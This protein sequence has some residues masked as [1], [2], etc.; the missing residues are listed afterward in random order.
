MRRVEVNTLL[1][2]SSHEILL[3]IEKSRCSLNTTNCFNNVVSLSI[4]NLKTKMI[5]FQGMGTSILNIMGWGFNSCHG[6]SLA[7]QGN[8]GKRGIGTEWKQTEV[9][10]PTAGDDISWEFC[11]K[12]QKLENTKHHDMHRY[13]LIFAVSW[14]S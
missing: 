14:A 10:P 8:D 2:W 5:G 12:S 7:I 9:S 4:F 11:C 3:Q 13:P 6:L 1:T